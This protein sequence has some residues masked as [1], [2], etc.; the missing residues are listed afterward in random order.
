[1]DVELGDVSLQLKIDGQTMRRKALLEN[2]VIKLR[3]VSSNLV[4][5]IIMLKYADTFWPNQGT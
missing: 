3:V 4:Y 1:M 2:N 5:N